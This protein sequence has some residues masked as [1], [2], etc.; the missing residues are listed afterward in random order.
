MFRRDCF[1]TPSAIEDDPSSAPPC[2][3]SASSLLD[4]E[5]DNCLAWTEK[6]EPRDYFVHN[7]DIW[8]CFLHSFLSINLER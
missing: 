8:L 6:K 3:W 7:P 2:F 5:P 4:T 1:L